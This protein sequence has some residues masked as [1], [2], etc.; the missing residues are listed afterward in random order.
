MPVVAQETTPLKTEEDTMSFVGRV[1]GGKGEKMR[2]E[3]E[4]RYA[5]PLDNF[6]FPQ[7]PAY[8]GIQTE[9]YKPGGEKGEQ[10]NKGSIPE[11]TTNTFGTLNSVNLD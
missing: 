1:M 6:N 2:S 8:E 3:E 5:D 10:L 9:F 11:H 4:D 7:I